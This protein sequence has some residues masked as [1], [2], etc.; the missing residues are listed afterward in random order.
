MEDTVEREIGGL[1][2]RIKRYACIAT[3][4]CMKVAGNT[5][6]FD[7]ERVCS[8]RLD[9][10]TIDRERLIEACRVCPVNALIVIDEQG[11]QLVP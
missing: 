7:A 5:F 6:E 4:N 1:T 8:F 3:G 11:K 10:T 2:I 9:E